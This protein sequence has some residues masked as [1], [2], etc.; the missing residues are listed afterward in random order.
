LSG[1]L[2]SSQSGF[3]YMRGKPFQSIALAALR[4]TLRL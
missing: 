4:Q 2:E 3:V 1:A